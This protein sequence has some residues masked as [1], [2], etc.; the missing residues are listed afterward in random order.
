MDPAWAEWPTLCAST[1][2][3]VNT[4]TRKFCAS[5]WQYHGVMLKYKTVWRRIAPPLSFLAGWH[6]FGGNTCNPE[7]LPSRIHAYPF[8]VQQRSVLLMNVEFIGKYQSLMSRISVTHRHD[9][10]LASSSPLA[11]DSHPHD[12]NLQETPCRQLA[13]KFL[14]CLVRSRPT[15]H[16][17][18]T[19]TPH[20]VGHAKC[21]Y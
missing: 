11:G 12:S 18:P 16:R 19:P 3:C 6:N 14:A 4:S 20:S 2:Q 7:Q 17:P 5:D 21:E 9:G 15:V 13:C 1:T 10:F 8:E